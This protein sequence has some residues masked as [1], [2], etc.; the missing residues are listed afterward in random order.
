MVLAV[1]VGITMFFTED[2]INYLKTP[3]GDDKLT[4]LDPTGSVVI[5]FRV[6]LMSGAILAIPYITYQ[7]LMFIMPGLKQQ[8]KRWVMTAIPVTTLFFLTGVAFAWF[9]MIPAA[10]TFLRD[11]Q[12]QSFQAEWT[13]QNYFA[14][15]TM[16]LFW[17][18][19]A[20]EMPVIF[21]VLAKLG[22]VSQ[23]MLIK[24]WR[25]AI[26]V[27]T[28]IA[29][30]ITPT[31][32]PFNMLLVMIPLLGLYLVSIVMVGI[33]ARGNSPKTQAV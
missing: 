8:E 14:F 26:V 19:V 10:F 13:A 16:I 22:L 33:A 6:A 24:N 23:R 1:C 2:I 17:M 11:F 4:I 30:V 7:L 31:V 25:A 29:A 12:G 3:Y 27:N 18:G 5:Y 32:D 20:F 15:L 9:I 21:Y 28:I